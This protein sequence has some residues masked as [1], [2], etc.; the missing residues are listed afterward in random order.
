MQNNNKRQV[1]YVITNTNLIANVYLDL[2][3]HH[4]HQLFHEHHLLKISIFVGLVLGSIVQVIYS[5]F[6]SFGS[7]HLHIQNLCKICK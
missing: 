7:Y 1:I 5:N 2:V 3:I 4:K 6:V